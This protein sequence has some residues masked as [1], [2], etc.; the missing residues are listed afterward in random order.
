[1]SHEIRTP[2]NGI[3][4]FTSLLKKPQLTG[5]KKDKYIQIIEKSGQRMLSTINDI[6]D[7]SKIEAGQVK[8]EKTHGLVNDL[9]KEQYDFFYREAS[10]KGLKLLYNP[11]LPDSESDIITD[12]HKLQGILTNLIKNAIKFTETGKVEFGYNA[13]NEKNRA[14]LEFYVSDTGIGIAQDRIEAIFNR[15]EQADIE[16]KKAYEGTGLGL[17]ISLSYV[18][19]LGGKIKVNSKEG[20]GSIFTFSIPYIKTSN[21]QQI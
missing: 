12:W 6:V 11:A 7:I 1:M 18:E 19:M 17:A 21:N 10:K 4:A 20:S 2:M 14:T 9:M 3:L 5:D 13:K 15:F 16:D 8:V